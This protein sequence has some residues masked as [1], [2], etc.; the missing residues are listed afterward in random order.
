MAPT[1]LVA[2]ATG[3]TGRNVVRTL[4]NLLKA[5]NVLPGYRILALTRSSNGTA[6]QQLAELPGVEVVEQSWVEVTADWLRQHQVARAYIASHNQTNQ[7]AEESTFHLAA[8]HAGVKY[9]VRISTT[10]ANVRPDCGAFYPRAH[11]AIEALLST[12]EF[13]DLQ[14]TSLQANIFSP[15]FLGSA[16]EFVKNYRETG[17]QDTLKLLA[18]EDAPVGIIDPDDV[19]AFAA[20]LLVQDD[21]SRHNKAK[22]V[23]NGPEDITGHQIVKMVEDRI[24]TQVKDVRYKDTSIIEQMAAQS[25]E[26]KNVML[27]LR[28]AL[29]TA[30]A[31]ECSASTTSKEVLE[32]AAPKGTPTDMFK[33]LV[34]G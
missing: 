25:S 26:S 33:T 5:N 24:G 22:Y 2:G 13:R 32:L 15:L 18:S 34:E 16:V 10:A 3:N 23:L 7:F 17:K 14:W 1:I 27:S 9:V 6:A 28:H 11:W 29:E 12:P 8:L 31:G 21:P 30:W 4:S 20:H 19:G